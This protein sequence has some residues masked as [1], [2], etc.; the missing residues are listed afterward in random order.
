[1]RSVERGRASKL[2]RKGRRALLA[3]PSDARTVGRSDAGVSALHAQALKAG[4]SM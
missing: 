1:V 2:R 3:E 4:W